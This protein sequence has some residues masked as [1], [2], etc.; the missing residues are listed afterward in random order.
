MITSVRSQG[1]GHGIQEAA[2][3]GCCS[4]VPIGEPSTAV[5]IQA[6]AISSTPFS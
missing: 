3:G 5:A 1:T 6:E 2:M 4:I